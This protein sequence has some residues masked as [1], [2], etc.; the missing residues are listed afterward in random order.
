MLTKTQGIV[1]RTIK[2]SDKASIA[3]IYT[4]EYG[5][6]SFMVYGVAG[7]KSGTK[8]AM[9]SPLSLVELN[10]L[11]M[12]GK[13]IQQLRELRPLET[14]YAISL[15]PVKNAIALFLA[16]LFIKTLRQ[17]QA[18]EALFDFLSNAI[19]QLHYI[20]A[21]IANFH[22][23]LM[24]KLTRFMGFYPNRSDAPF[25][26]F[27]L[28]NGEFTFNA[29]LHTHYI[30]HERTLQLAKLLE[31]QFTN[32]PD[33]NIGRADR[34]ALLEAMIEYYRLHVADFHGLNSMEVLHELFS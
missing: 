22:L 31:V 23:I 3:T 24:L 11:F 8:G 4:R 5:R 19:R 14:S 20:D 21:G 28:M 26:Y 2:Y 34:I 27:D 18:D 9:L 13:E 29:P 15:D 7:R 33:L 30:N 10:C 6:V 25:R 32:L 1:L 17:P 12:P 16:E